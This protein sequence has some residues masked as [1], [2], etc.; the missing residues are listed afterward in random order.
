MEQSIRALVE[1][2]DTRMREETAFFDGLGQSLD[3]LRAAFEGKRWS[4]AVATAEG[5][6]LSARSIERADAA[7]DSAFVAL[8][9]ALDLP[10]ETAFSAALP[11]LPADQRASLEESWRALRM[12]VVRLKTGSSRMRYAAESLSRMLNRIL[13]EA[14]PYRK[15]KIYSRRGTPTSVSGALIVD[16]KL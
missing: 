9:E 15:G 3:T 11:S 16:H 5:I 10:R 12:S 8:R 14:F 1:T 13:D 4:E 7:R 2:L 6:Q